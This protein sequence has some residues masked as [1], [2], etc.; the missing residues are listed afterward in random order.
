MLEEIRRG[1]QEAPLAPD[2]RGGDEVD[3]VGTRKGEELGD[4][5]NSDEIMEQGSDQVGW[6][7]P[8]AVGC[9]MG[10]VV[11]GRESRPQ[12]EGPHG[13]T[14]PPKETHAGH[15]RTGST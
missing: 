5:V 9:L 15:C 14:K 8:N 7:W 11:G 10:Q 13:S 1:T 2:T 12:G 3:R 6:R 4:G